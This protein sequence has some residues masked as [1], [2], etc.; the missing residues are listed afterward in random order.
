MAAAAME[1]VLEETLQYTKERKAFGRPI[2]S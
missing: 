2:G 1:P